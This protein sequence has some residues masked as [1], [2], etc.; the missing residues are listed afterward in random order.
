MFRV[1]SSL[2]VFSED[3]S[4]IILIAKRCITLEMSS[5]VALATL[6]D[7]TKMAL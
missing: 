7:N 5:D 6:L 2:I 1:L 4:I 3:V